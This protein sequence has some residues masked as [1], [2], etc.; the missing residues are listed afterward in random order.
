LHIA[1]GTNPNEETKIENHT[2]KLE[3]KIINLTPHPLTLVGDN[4]TLQVPPSGQLARLAVTRTA[5][6][7]VTIDGVT[8][9]V[10]RPSLG[11]I[12]GLPP[13][14]EGVILIVSALVAEAANRADVY[15]PGELLRSP[16]GVVIGAK[17]LCSYYGEG[18]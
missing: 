2:M 3:Q 8:L 1:N 9:P 18:K 4:G 17:G 10:S 16:E 14:E 5:L 15:S 13:A 6:D 12:T 7:S 11:E